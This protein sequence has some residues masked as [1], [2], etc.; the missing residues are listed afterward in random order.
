MKL[1]KLQILSCLA[2]LL[3]P[4]T[5]SVVPVYA[6]SVETRGNEVNYEVT[7]DFQSLELTVGASRLVTMPFDVPKVV[8]E[9]PSVVVATPVSRNQVLVRGLQTGITGVSFSDSLEKSYT[10]EINVVNDVRQLQ[11][12]LNQTFPTANINVRPLKGSVVL[13]GTVPSPE[14]SAQ[15]VDVA[16]KFSD[17]VFQNLQVSGAQNVALE[18]KVYE[19][20]R[21]KLRRLGIDWSFSTGKTFG[22]QSVSDILSLDNNASLVTSNSDTLQFSVLNGNNTFR[23]MIEALEQHDVAKL[24]DEPTLVTLNGRPAEFLEGGEVPILVNAGLGVASV[25]FRP[26]GTKVDFLPIVLGGG[27]LRLDLR[28]EVSQVAEGLSGDTDTP[29]FTVRRANVGVEMN[30]GETLV[31]AGDIQERTSNT[32][33]GIPGLMH[34]PWV[35]AAFR[36]NEETVL[37]TELVVIATP[38][39]IGGVDPSMLPALGPGEATHIATNPEFYWRGYMEVPRCDPSIEQSRYDNYG[40]GVPSPGHPGPGYP[41]PGYQGPVNAPGNMNLPPQGNIPAEPISGQRN[42]ATGGYQPFGAPKR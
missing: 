1:F 2:C 5:S 34:M 27:R 13:V 6:Q 7:K 28:Y 37:E 23:A 24:L 30:A 29:G 3:G 8:V 32:K 11:A 9:D 39:F 26:F 12:V 16:K 25:E 15:V 41:A 19:V 38:R 17:E 31:I 22:F 18:M 14:M 36:K 21:N 4:L 20:S 40:P 35:G 10:V 42:P 33:R